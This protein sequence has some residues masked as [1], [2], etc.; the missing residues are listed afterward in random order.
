MITADTLVTR[1]KAQLPGVKSIGAS[2]ELD[3]AI[4]GTPVT[5]SLFVIPLAESVTGE[6]DT[7]GGV[8]QEV[9]QVFGVAFVVSNQ[10][11]VRGAAALNDLAPLRQATQ[12]ALLGWVP[13]AATGEPLLFRGGRL[14]RLDGNGRIWWIDEFQV[15]HWSN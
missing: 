3:A 14:L 5:P 12:A 8:D 11:D 7:T 2:A 4:A 1:L 15:T 10:R 9:L 13:D 6:L